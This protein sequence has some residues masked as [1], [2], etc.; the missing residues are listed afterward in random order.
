MDP[1]FFSQQKRRNKL[2]SAERT[3]NMQSLTLFVGNRW[4]C[5]ECGGALGRYDTL[6]V[7]KLRHYHAAMF[8]S[9]QPVFDVGKNLQSRIAG[10][11]SRD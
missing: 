1:P 11:L 3:P 10:S 4:R 6:A 8:Q 5:G 9:S 7:S 2:Y